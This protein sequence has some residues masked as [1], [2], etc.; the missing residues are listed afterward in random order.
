M[1]RDQRSWAKSC[2]SRHDDDGVDVE[3]T[4][5]LHPDVLGLVILDLALKDGATV[6]RDA[7]DAAVALPTLDGGDERDGPFL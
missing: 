6:H 7:Y 1:S 5:P 4:L 2:R 3:L